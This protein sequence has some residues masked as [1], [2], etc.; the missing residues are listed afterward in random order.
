MGMYDDILKQMQGS[1]MQNNP[2]MFGK[3]GGFSSSNFNFNDPDVIKPGGGG[4]V[5]GTGGTDGDIPGG[6]GGTGGTGGGSSS[7]GPTSYGGQFNSNFSSVQDILSRIGQSDYDLSNPASQFG[8]GEDYE[9][10]FGSF[11]IQ[12]YNEAQ[13]ALSQMQERG[14]K[15]IGQQFKSNKLG[16]QGNL[17]DTL[18]GMRAEE[19]TKG[20][21]SGRSQRR[22][23][24]TRES[25]EQK[26][27]ELGRATQQRYAGLEESIG[28]KAGALEGTLLDFIG[29]QAGIA[30]N[31]EQSDATK[32][33]DNAGPSSWFN[34]QRGTGYSSTSGEM[35][36][37][38]AQFGD[39]GDSSAAA[40][41]DF[42]NKAHSNLSQAQLQE[43]FN[44]VYN[45]F[46]QQSESG[47][48][49]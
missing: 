26:Y 15:D 8:Y 21:D 33:S 18:L 7:Y 14:F 17:Q 4:T 3:P 10:Y 2:K 47:E 13:S 30:L 49:G 35:T 5:G 44:D 25:G 37:F 6:T 11:D 46:Q 42:V 9:D 48:D 12:G 31:L 39:L 23:D 41:Q 20:F 16:L 27:G 34:V 28:Q 29:K 40:Y 38:Q 1:F 43:L 24:L 32:Q 22:R 45:Q 19:S 36:P